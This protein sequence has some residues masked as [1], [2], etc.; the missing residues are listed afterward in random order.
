MSTASAQSL[1]DRLEED[2]AFASQLSERRDDA[3]AVQAMI[4]E[5]GFEV[6]PEEMHEIFLERYG[7]DL[8]E[9]QLEAI[10]GGVTGAEIAAGTILGGVAVVGIAV[11]AAAA[12][13]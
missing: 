7:A 1:F 6:T 3:D 8:T 11:S 9:E 2:D 12:A 5:A 4:R 10:A 13:I